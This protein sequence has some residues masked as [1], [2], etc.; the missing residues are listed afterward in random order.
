[1]GEDRG[2]ERE[3]RFP[4]DKGLIQSLSGTTCE[5]IGEN[6]DVQEQS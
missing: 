5:Q 2:S 4:P 1:M 3:K 6:F